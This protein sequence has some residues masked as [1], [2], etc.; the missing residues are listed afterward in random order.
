M[1]DLKVQL[2]VNEM[3][4]QMEH[5]KQQTDAKIKSSYQQ[6]KDKETELHLKAIKILK[7]EK[8]FKDR[9]AEIFDKKDQISKME[10][11][12]Q[13][14]EAQIQS[15]DKSIRE[16][17]DQAN[18]LKQK[19]KD[20]SEASSC[21]PFTNSTEIHTISLP[22]I[23]PFVV[24]CN[25]SVSGSGWTVI[26][27]R[28]NVYF[29]RIFNDYK[30]GFGDLRKNFFLGMEKIHQMTLLQPHELYIQLQ[31]V[32]GETS[33]ARYDDFKVGSEKEKYELISLGKY[34]GTAA[35]SL[36]HLNVNFF[37]W[38]LDNAGDKEVDSEDEDRDAWWCR[39][40]QEK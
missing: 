9:E 6:L 3:L 16:L 36:A 12:T 13:S 29:N 38:D 14:R 5:L 27:R 31:H 23:D 22:G 39:Y 20:I 37:L 2:K 25:S 21:L 26:H 34:S 24:P 1:E 17:E 32:N 19:L 8:D 10:M 30:L 11:Q 35:D 33:Y 7:I 15:K 4:K 40:L 28:N 18:S